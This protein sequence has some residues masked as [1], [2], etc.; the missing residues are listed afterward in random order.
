MSK[1]AAIILWTFIGF[2]SACVGILSATH[3]YFFFYPPIPV[4]TFRDPY[5]SVSQMFTLGPIKLRNE[6]IAIVFGLAFVTSLA[7]TVFAIRQCLSQTD[8]AHE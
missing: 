3:F 8:D 7:I 5:I 6:Q 1:W 4:E 2:F